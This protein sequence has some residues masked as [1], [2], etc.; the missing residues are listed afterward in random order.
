MLSIEKING[1]L[2]I[3]INCEDGRL[4]R[5][6]SCDNSIKTLFVFHSSS[7]PAC[8]GLEE[9]LKFCILRFTEIVIY[10]L[11]SN[12]NVKREKLLGITSNMAILPTKEIIKNA[13]RE[14]KDW[15]SFLEYIPN[16]NDFYKLYTSASSLSMINYTVLANFCG[17]TDFCKNV[18]NS[19]TLRRFTNF[20]EQTLQV[21]KKNMTFEMYLSEVKNH[22]KYIEDLYQI[23][24]EFEL[25][26]YDFL[27]FILLFDIRKN[28]NMLTKKGH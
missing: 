7:L 6:L 19:K 26:E 20:Q 10:L 13:M 22:K 9:R 28:R 3:P 27:T 4:M 8:K 23:Y 14:I 21:Y 15:Y 1:L 17:I 24:T 18:N 16:E 2:N 5:L 11:N 12:G 25:T